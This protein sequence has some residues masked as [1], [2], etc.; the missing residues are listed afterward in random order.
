MVAPQ[1]ARQ[2][3]RTGI[4]QH[5]DIAHPVWVAVERVAVAPATQD[6]ATVNIAQILRS[7]RETH[8]SMRAVATGA[9]NLERKTGETTG[10]WAD[11]LTLARAQ[12]D[13]V[14]V[15]LLIA[16]DHGIWGPRYYKSGWAADASRYFYAMRWYKRTPEGKLLFNKNVHALKVRAKAVQVSAKEWIAT[17]AD[18]RGSSLRF[19]AIKGDRIDPFPTP[20]ASRKHLRGGNFDALAE[21]LYKNWKFLCDPAHA[22]LATVSLRNALR[23]GQLGR[24]GEQRYRDAINQEVIA[25][26][27]IPSLVAIITLTT[28]LAVRKRANHDVMAAV[29]NAW[30]TLEQGTVEGAILWENWARATLGVLPATQI[31]ASP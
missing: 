19:G 14:F 9:E 28:V 24:V 6:Y 17:L 21:L 12:F 10:R 26:S 1:Q 27:I 18:I 29:V 15:G 8:D 25:R 5:D 16:H 13:A 22:G 11:A 7:M 23:S 4:F 31:G 3:L 30:T 2:A 20:G